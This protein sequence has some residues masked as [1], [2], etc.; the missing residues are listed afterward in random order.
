MIKNITEYGFKGNQNNFRWTSHLFGS[1]CQFSHFIMKY[2]CK[3]EKRRIAPNIRSKNSLPTLTLV[4]LSLITV[5]FRTLQIM[6]RNSVLKSRQPVCT[7]YSDKFWSYTLHQE[8][9]Y[10]KTWVF[11]IHYYPQC[12]VCKY[13]CFF[14]CIIWSFWI[15]VVGARKPWAL[16]FNLQWHVAKLCWLSRCW[17]C[18]ILEKY[19]GQPQN[20]L[21]IE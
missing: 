12:I 4:L 18:N 3:S 15:A 19:T 5:P 6:F 21:S 13:A 17:W 9:F 11:C 10:I 16:L 1:F 14:G 8:C 7:K 2:T 20:T